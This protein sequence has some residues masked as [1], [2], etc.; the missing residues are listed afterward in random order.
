MQKTQISS[1]PKG[2][3]GKTVGLEKERED[4]LGKRMKFLCEEI[5]KQ[6]NDLTI[7]ETLT[8]YHWMQDWFGLRISIL[9][10]IKEGD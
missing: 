4:E 6:G 5:L 7:Q 1:G 2:N 8:L 3:P 9:E 10:N